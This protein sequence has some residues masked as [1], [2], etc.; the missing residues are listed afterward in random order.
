MR[1][2]PL[3]VFLDVLV[4]AAILVAA[5]VGFQGAAR[6]RRRP[7]AQLLLGAILGGTA[8]ALLLV[9]YALL[10]GAPAALSGGPLAWPLVG[11]LTGAAVGG[12]ALLARALGAWLAGRP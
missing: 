10:G 12:C 2:E 8:P 11:A 6:D 5:L 3:D 1:R 7:R 4:P 9:G